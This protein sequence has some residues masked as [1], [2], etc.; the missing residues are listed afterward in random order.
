MEG[1]CR[2]L[3]AVTVRSE[4]QMTCKASQV[5]IWTHGTPANKA[6]VRMRDFTLPPRSKLELRSSGL[7]RSEYG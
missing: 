6:K 7:L 1:S 5:Y 4:E 2:G 3:N